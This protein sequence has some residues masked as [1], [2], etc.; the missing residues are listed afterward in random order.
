MTHLSTQGSGL[1]VQVGTCQGHLTDCMNPTSRATSPRRVS[2]R[3]PLG[4]V[5]LAVR[6]AA[7]LLVLGWL[8]DRVSS[9]GGAGGGGHSTEATYEV[10]LQY[11]SLFPAARRAQLKWSLSEDR[12]SMYWALDQRTPV[13]GHSTCI[14]SFPF[15]INMHLIYC[16]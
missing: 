6:Y 9:P 5:P 1:A 4:A 12:D 8:R 16:E 2:R 3:L 13:A 10:L 7:G 11:E 15:P 14:F